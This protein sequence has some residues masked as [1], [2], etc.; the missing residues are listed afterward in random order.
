MARPR[1]LAALSDD[2]VDDGPEGPDPAPGVGGRH[3]ILAALAGRSLVGLRGALA[4]AGARTV[5]AVDVSGLRRHAAVLGARAA[6]VIDLPADVERVRAALTALRGQDAVVLLT[7]TATTGERIGLLAAGADHVL[8]TEDAGELVA[9]LSAVLRRTLPVRARGAGD[10][11]RVGGLC[12]DL[13]SRAATA[14]GRSLD[15]TALEFDLL[16]YFVSQA[17]RALTR[18]RLLADVWGYDVGG[19]ETVTVHVRR[20]RMKIEVDPSRPL[21]LRTLWGTGYRLESEVPAGAPALDRALGGAAAAVG[22]LRDR[23]ARL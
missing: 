2:E 20:L 22:D 16:A 13:R 8:D 15:L 7:T 23:A 1:R 17:G 18:E 6:M 4:G 14:D 21:L 10:V 19:L 3:V 12:V 5:D 11:L 9:C